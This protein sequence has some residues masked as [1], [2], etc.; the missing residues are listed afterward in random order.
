MQKQLQQLTE[1]VQNALA[2]RDFSQLAVA[3]T[4][5]NLK[6][7]DASRVL[8]NGLGPTPKKT[9]PRPKLDALNQ[10]TNSIK[11]ELVNLKK[12]QEDFSS[13]FGESIRLFVNQL[14]V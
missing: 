7:N 8:K 2:N 6:P 12:M 14:N 3:T 9:N 5:L 10:K 1:L 13:S 4:Q 11:S